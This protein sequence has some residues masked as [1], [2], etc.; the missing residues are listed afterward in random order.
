MDGEEEERKEKGWRE[1][2]RKEGECVNKGPCLS[3]S[4]QVDCPSLFL[5][6]VAQMT[7]SGLQV[8]IVLYNKYMYM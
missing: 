1:G 2:R 6:M 5:L 7:T 4:L 8:H 3:I